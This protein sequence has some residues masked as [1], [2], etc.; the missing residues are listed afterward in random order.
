MAV[1][2]TGRGNWSTRKNTDL[3]K[4]TDKFHH[5]K[6]YQ[7]HLNIGGNCNSMTSA[8]KEKTIV[9]NYNNII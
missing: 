2:F 4:V 1:C 5:I 3:P 8:L 6:L 9:N 7:V